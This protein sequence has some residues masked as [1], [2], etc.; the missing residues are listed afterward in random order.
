MKLKKLAILIVVLIAAI[1]ASYAI[2][3]GEARE[4][5]RVEKGIEELLEGLGKGDPD[6]VY[7]CLSGDSLRSDFDARYQDIADGYT[8]SDDARV[9]RER[10]SVYRGVSTVEY[11]VTVRVRDGER[12][13]FV[14][15]SA[16]GGKDGLHAVSFHDTLPPE[17]A[18]EGE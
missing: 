9:S 3:F 12:T 6:A 1:V 17:D 15:A 10:E 2:T 7:A 4:F 8:P 11:T 13:F 14:T 5:N 18:T 16:V